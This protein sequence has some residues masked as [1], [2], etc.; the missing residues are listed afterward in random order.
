MSN[1][2]QQRADQIRDEYQH[3]ERRAMPPAVIQTLQAIH[4]DPFTQAAVWRAYVNLPI[5]LSAPVFLALW[6]ADQSGVAQE[7]HW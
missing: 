4:P 5:S 1:L 2:A 7:V 6:D 3:G